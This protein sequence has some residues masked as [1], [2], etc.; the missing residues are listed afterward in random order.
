MHG[1]GSELAGQQ[2]H[3]PCYL[4]AVAVAEAGCT[5]SSMHNPSYPLLIVP[6]VANKQQVK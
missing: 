2:S 4:S 5:T 1:C 6:A 3:P